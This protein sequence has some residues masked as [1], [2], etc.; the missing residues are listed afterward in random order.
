[1]MHVTTIRP[2]VSDP[3]EKLH[4][5]NSW[6][7]IDGNSVIK[8][9]GTHKKLAKLEKRWKI[10]IYV[11][12]MEIE[13][14]IY[15]TTLMSERK[16]FEFFAFPLWNCE[17]CDWQLCGESV[18]VNRCVEP[19][20]PNKSLNHLSHRTPIK[21][22]WKLSQ[23][24]MLFCKSRCYCDTTHLT[25]SHDWWRREFSFS[26]SIFITHSVVGFSDFPNAMRKDEKV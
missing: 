6:K 14:K 26:I 16:C 1:M 22:T 10:R 3:H 23:R 9:F 2:H 12:Q 5:G 24:R 21:M 13:R 4:S 8:D 18:I 25:L 17:N 19:N 11:L 7:S 20:L 15:F